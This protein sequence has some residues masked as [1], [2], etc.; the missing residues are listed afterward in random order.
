[1]MNF[2]DAPTLDQVFSL[3]KWDGEKWTCQAAPL[4][5]GDPPSDT[6]PLVNGVNIPGLE[7]KYARGDHIHPT[8]T[9]RAKPNNET[10][11]GTTSGPGANVSGDLGVS[12]VITAQAAGGG[13]RMG[14]HSGEA[15]AAMS[16]ADANIVLYDGGGG[17]WAGLG[18]DVNGRFFVR[19]G[20]SGSPAAAFWIDQSKTAQ[21]LKTPIS[22]TPG[23]GDNSNKVATTNFVL[24]NPASGPFL[25]L[26]GGTVTTGIMYINGDLR[27]YRG[28]GNEGVLFLNNAGNR[29]LH[30]TANDNYHLVSAHC[31]SAAGRLWGNGDFSQPIVNIRLAYLADQAVAAAAGMTESYG[32]GVETGGSA[33]ASTGCTHRFRQFQIQLGAD[34]YAVGYV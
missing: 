25:P 13:H 33:C 23:A 19:T 2:P 15:N 32:G 30:Y 31:Y 26:T 18:T 27:V 10:L 20:L 12:G 9:S 11:T 34:W 29:Y 7:Y 6:N 4:T 17:N 24:S 5:L 14:V 16:I 22:P 21:F 28:T 1:M 8:D 3:Y